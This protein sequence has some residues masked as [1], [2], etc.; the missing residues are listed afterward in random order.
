M[1][2]S[3]REEEAPWRL[4]HTIADAAGWPR[5]AGLE[6]EGCLE[7]AELSLKEPGAMRREGKAFSAEGTAGA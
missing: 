5:R 6:R 1:W 7:K 2:D 4:S 3:T